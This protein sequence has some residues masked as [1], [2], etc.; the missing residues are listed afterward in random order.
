MGLSCWTQIWEF[1]GPGLLAAL[2]AT[3]WSLKMKP[4]WRRIE[5]T[6]AECRGP[7]DMTWA[8]LEPTNPGTSHVPKSVNSPSLSW[9]FHPLQQKESWL[10][11]QWRRYAEGQRYQNRDNEGTKEN[12]IYGRKEFNWG[13]SSWF[14]DSLTTELALLLN[15]TR[16]TVSSLPVILT[17]NLCNCLR[18]LKIRTSFYLGIKFHLYFSLPSKLF[19]VI[20]LIQA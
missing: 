12:M 11:L 2:F 1:A 7:D 5:L 9:I 3:L 19:S 18:I 6:E 4:M 14:P 16:E 13:Q 15:N 17:G 10:V 20:M 8:A